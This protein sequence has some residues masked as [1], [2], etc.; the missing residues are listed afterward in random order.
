MILLLL[1]SSLA[2][3]VYSFTRIWELQNEG[4]GR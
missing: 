1:L 4:W 3:A 2:A